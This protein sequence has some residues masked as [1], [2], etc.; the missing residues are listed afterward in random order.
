[1]LDNN[2]DLYY[3]DQNGIMQTAHL[4]SGDTFTLKHNDTCT[5]ILPRGKNVTISE[6]NENYIS[7]FQLGSAPEEKTNHKT[8]V[9]DG[10][11]TLAVTNTLDGVLPT[12]IKLNVPVF[13]PIAVG[14]LAVILLILH[15]KK[16][17]N[18]SE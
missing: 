16:L 18:N 6:N 9:L 2:Y 3:F 13:L 17:K 14:S 1:M 5:V 4:H 8:F 15:L 12:G 11:I 10:N 7:S